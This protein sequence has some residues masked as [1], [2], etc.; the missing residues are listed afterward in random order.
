MHLAKKFAN[1]FIGQMF[2]QHLFFPADYFTYSS[3]CRKVEENL[4]FYSGCASSGFIEKVWDALCSTS[5]RRFELHLP[6]RTAVSELPG[7][8]REALQI[9]AWNLSMFEIIPVFQRIKLNPDGSCELVYSSVPCTTA[10]L[11]PRGE[12]TMALEQGQDIHRS[13]LLLEPETGWLT[14]LACMKSSDHSY[15]TKEGLKDWSLPLSSSL[16]NNSLQ[17]Q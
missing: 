2:Q 17:L 13:A 5:G 15:Q 6:W 12:Q 14:G 3:C 7:R 10:S 11:P 1:A 16:E 9:T 8:L 4:D